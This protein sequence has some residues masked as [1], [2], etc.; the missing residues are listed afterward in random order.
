LDFYKLLGV[1]LRASD[2]EIK[3]S[4]RQKAKIYHPD[5]NKAPDAGDTFRMLYVAYDTLSDPFKRKMY[6]EIL[7]GGMIPSEELSNRA[8]QEKMRRRADIRA[9]AYA[10]MEYEEFEETAF[11]KA[12]FHAKQLVAFLIFFTLLCGGM[13][14]FIMGANYVFIED[15]NGAKVAGY[16]F[17]VAGLLLTYISGKALLDIYEIWRS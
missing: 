11:T 12:S 2:A 13:A 10:A 14:C 5:I 9:R 16:G 3:Q 17:W 15:F 8:Y 7:E 1:S 4:F 6:D